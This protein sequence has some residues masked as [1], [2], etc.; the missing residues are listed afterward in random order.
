MSSQLLSKIGEEILADARKEAERKIEEAQ[1]K[2]EEIFEKARREAEAE[3]ETIKT[4]AMEDIKVMEERK[5]S[6]ARREASVQI[7]KGK[8]ELIAQA[9]KL[10]SKHL[11]EVVEKEVYL[12]SL[13]QIIENSSPLLGDENVKI[14]LNRRDLQHEHELHGKLKLSSNLGLTF[15]KQPINTVGGCILLTEDERVRIDETFETR[16]SSAER[17]LKKEISNILFAD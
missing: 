7:L 8:N 11:N 6:E 13:L 16:L 1:K 3:A 12:K 15:D 9:F 4:K 14:R 17:S 5:L 10:A 2:A